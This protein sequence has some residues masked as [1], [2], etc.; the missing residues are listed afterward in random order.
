[1][2]SCPSKN[3]ADSLPE[4]RRIDRSL[5]ALSRS[6]LSRPVKLAINDGFIAAESSVFD[7]GCGRGDD[8]RFLTEMGI[9]ADGWDPHYRSSSLQREA[10]IVNLG[11]ILNVI[12]DGE[13][14]LDVVSRAWNLARKLLIV[15]AQVVLMIASVTRFHITMAMSPD[16][17]H[18][19]D[20]SNKANSKS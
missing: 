7:F 6:E 13:E 19:S 20:S 9:Q 2:K 14:R 17:G 18:S 16:E 5:T 8:I 3:D 4:G 10:D 12:E 15:A 11:Y 1:M